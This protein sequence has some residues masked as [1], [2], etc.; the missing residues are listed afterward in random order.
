MELGAFT[1]TPRHHSPEVH[2]L[3]QL[4]KCIFIF[5]TL[6]NKWLIQAHFLTLTLPS[7]LPY[8]R[9]ILGE[10]DITDK[11]TFGEI[12]VLAH[13]YKPKLNYI[14]YN[15]PSLSSLTLVDYVRS[16]VRSGSVVCCRSKNLRSY[17]LGKHVFR[18]TS[19]INCLAYNVELFWRVYVLLWSN[20]YFMEFVID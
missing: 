7:G 19:Y 12:G 14:L 9:A 6:V 15:N 4:C 18:R 2:P 16:E 17:L 1:S 3:R 11:C 8:L 20:G 13:K 10:N 5:M